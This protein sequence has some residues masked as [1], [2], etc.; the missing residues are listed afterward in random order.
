M[1]QIDKAKMEDVESIHGLINAAA[2]RQQML[3]RSLQSIYENLRAFVVCRNEK[4]QVIGCC[5]MEIVWRD[6]GEIR[7][8]V[9]SSR[10]RGKGIGALLVSSCLDEA[11]S[12]GIR[13]IFTLTYVEDFFKKLGFRKLDK[14]KLPHKIWNDCINCPHFPDCDEVALITNL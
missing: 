3:A 13:K 14:K 12:L 2:V 8:L 7:S 6:M 10:Y 1:F 4:G 9:V 11:K 5:A